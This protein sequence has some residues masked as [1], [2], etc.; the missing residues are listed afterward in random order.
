MIS[1]SVLASCPIE[2][3]AEATQTLSASVCGNIIE[4]HQNL[5]GNPMSNWWKSNPAV[6]GLHDK[7]LYSKEKE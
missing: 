3:S 1:D 4:N 6:D 7:I 5:E 2:K